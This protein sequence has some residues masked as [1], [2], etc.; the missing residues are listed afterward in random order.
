MC[1]SVNNIDINKLYSLVKVGNP[2]HNDRFVRTEYYIEQYNVT[3]FKLTEGIVFDKLKLCF[4]DDLG[5]KAV[6]GMDI[7]GLFEIL[8]L[9]NDE[10]CNGSFYLRRYRETKNLVD[11]Y[12]AKSKTDILYPVTILEMM[13]QG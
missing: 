13:R 5:E 8:Y 2:L 7:L 3:D 4:S 6:I 12:L 10:H 11:K 1:N 9:F